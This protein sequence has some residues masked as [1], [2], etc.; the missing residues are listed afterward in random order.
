MRTRKYKKSIIG[1]DGTFLG[2]DLVGAGAASRA[3]GGTRCGVVASS[4][5]PASSL[6]DG[7]GDRRVLAPRT[8]AAAGNAET[9]L[10]G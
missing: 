1:R 10:R 4:A 7:A 2:T 8:N 5:R 6:G 3:D 9:G